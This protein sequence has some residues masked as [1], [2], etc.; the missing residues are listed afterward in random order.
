M[1]L[2]SLLAKLTLD[3]TEYDKGLEDAEKDANNL[4]LPTPKLPKV[5]NTDFDEG[6][7]KAEEN[8]NIFKDVMTGVWEGLKSSIATAGI[9]GAVMGVVG[10]MRQGIDMA[11]EN[12]DAIKKG[13][14]NLGIS[15]KAY[16]EYE[17]ALGKSGLKIKD[18]STAIKRM[19]ELKG[20]K[21]LTDDQKKFVEE[22]GIS[23]EE[24]A[25]KEQLLGDIMKSLAGYTGDD[26]GRII[27]W[28]FGSNQNWE[29]YFSQT[30]SEIEKLKSDA[31]DMG[32]IM[33]DDAIDNASEF[34]D[35]TEEISNRIE[36]IKRSFGESVLPMLTDAVK[37]VAKIVTFF[38][39]G[40]KS[41][42][43]IFAG[44]D[45]E[46]AD[47][48]STIEGTGAAAESLADKLLKMGDTAQMTEQ[49]YAIW[50]GTAKE[51]ISL[52]PSLG[53]VIDLESDQINANSAE[54]KENIKQWQELAKQKAVQA[55]K[56]KKMQE[57][58]EKNQELIQKSIEANKLAADAEGER[59]KALEG[60]NG[61]LQ[62][63]GM[64]TLGENATSEDVTAAKQKLMESATDDS[65]LSQILSDWSAVAGEW[66]KVN[67]EAKAAE[68]QAAD[69]Q[70]QLDDA[71]KEYDDWVA[72]I[73]R[74]YGTADNDAQTA[75]DQAKELKE[76]IDSIPDYKRI[77][78]QEERMGSY[79]IGSAYIP[80]DQPAMLH[81]GER[82]LTATENRRG[83]RSQPDFS[84]LEDKIIDAIKA[85]MDGVEVNSYLDGDLVTDK[86]SKKL[87]RQLADRRY[88]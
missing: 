65:Q 1:D 62:K 77:T 78:I 22:L 16:Q 47:Q 79:A 11:I 24:A 49:E 34:K 14:A 87:A 42:S 19:D 70:K 18:L 59:K 82:I 29:S 85:G 71:V 4:N 26:K 37:M 5:D 48:L 21:E 15:T 72:A 67:N 33:S 56:E 31:K 60:I 23:A 80:Y 41:L 69:L 50:K 2:M 32:L 3:K 30:A 6:L 84:G 8:G 27:D 68:V 81:R 20:G 44:D 7:S 17:Y 12:G 43:E 86:V 54:I 36:S 46:L 13:A 25:D 53:E 40:E 61:V 10:A 66:T 88:V 76:A 9:V 45:K 28:L 57:V 35:A 58:T 52:V 83:E 63:Y 55:T 51:L 75:T 74:L 38:S 39:G 73:D 64:E